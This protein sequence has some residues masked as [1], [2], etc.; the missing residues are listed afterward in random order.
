MIVTAIIGIMASVAYP[1]YTSSILRSKRA[2]AKVALT[3]LANMQEKY[4]INNQ[5]YGDLTDLGYSADTLALDDSGDL[6]GTG[7]SI[8]NVTITAS[9]TAYTLQATATGGQTSDSEG[10]TSCSPLKLDNAGDQ[11]PSDCW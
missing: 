2:L 8:Y 5:S 7:T 6:G 9:T 1:S 11:T 4:F 3:N 10:S